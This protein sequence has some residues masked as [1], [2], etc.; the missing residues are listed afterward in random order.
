MNF[1]SRLLPFGIMRRL[2]VYYADVLNRSIFFEPKVFESNRIQGVR[3]K[4]G[5]AK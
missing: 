5:E 2:L 3:I 1:K 4:Y